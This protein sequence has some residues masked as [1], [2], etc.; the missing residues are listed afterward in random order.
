MRYTGPKCRLCRREGT[1]LFLKGERCYPNKCPIDRKGPVAP[2]QHGMKSGWRISDY[3]KHLRAKQRVRR[4]Y[5]LSEQQFKNYFV[6][7]VKAKSNA[8]LVL[9]QLLETRLDTVVYRLGFVSSRHTA[10]QMIR[11][12]MILVDGKKVNIPSYQ[13]RPD[14]VVS[15]SP[16]GTK[17]AEVKAA[18]KNDGY[19][20][21]DWLS[22]KAMAGKLVRL[23]LREEIE[24]DF[25]EDLIVEFYS[26]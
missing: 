9:L 5:N 7:A 16:K 1:K 21:P 22:K 11:H 4:F 26:R 17:H 20:V 24:T 6:Q 19:K 8:G 15:L 18:A 13:V 14:Q 2:G 25:E 12:G 3:G 23:P 10:R